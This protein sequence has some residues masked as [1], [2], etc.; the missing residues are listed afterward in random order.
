MYTHR[1]Q[2]TGT[3]GRPRPGSASS[4]HGIPPARATSCRRQPAEPEGRTH[5]MKI[6]WLG[7]RSTGTPSEVSQPRLYITAAQRPNQDHG[8]P[9]EIPGQTG[10]I[11]LIT[12][13]SRDSTEPPPLRPLV[14]RAPRAGVQAPDSRFLSAGINRHGEGDENALRRRGSDP[15]WP[16][17]MRRR[18]QGR[19]RSVDRGTCRPGY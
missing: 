13:W 3:P 5:P 7:L 6:P 14:R 16:R 12:R 11:G 2:A 18:P 8:R 1:S 4:L 15:R 10:R 19:R 9:P 17:V